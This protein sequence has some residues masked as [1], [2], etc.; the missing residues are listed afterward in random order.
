MRR[1]LLPAVVVLVGS[2]ATLAGLVAQS[3]VGQ[4]HGKVT[5]TSGAALPGTDVEIRRPAGGERRTVTDAKGEFSFASLQPGPYSVTAS[6]RG[7]R[8]ATK[9]VT[10]AAG[11]V[12][13]ITFALAVA[14]VAETVT[15]TGET[16][17]V[18]VQAVAGGVGGGRGIGLGWRVAGSPFNTEAYDKIDDNQWTAVGRKPW[19]TLSIDVDTAS[20]AN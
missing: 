17:T 4:L 5:D 15:V 18:D 1:F 9:P 16:P 7:F 2:L 10:V 11:S 8:S 14:G 3:N 13:T 6:L 19:S 20:Y 12:T